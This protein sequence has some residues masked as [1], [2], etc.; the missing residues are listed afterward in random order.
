VPA[1]E[2]LPRAQALA[3]QIARNA[4]LAVRALKA[5]LGLDP[6]ALRA[7]LENEAFR[8]A[9]S[10]GSA[11]LGEGLAAAVERRAAVFTGA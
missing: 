10:Y 2:V 8:Q 4:P 9:E 11:D 7:A 5:S 3:A 6:A 1:A